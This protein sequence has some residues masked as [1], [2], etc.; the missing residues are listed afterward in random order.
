[1]NIITKV[2]HRFFP[3]IVIILI[4][5]G[6]SCL[7]SPKERTNQLDTSI[8]D[9]IFTLTYEFVYPDNNQSDPKVL[10]SWSQVDHELLAGYNVYRHDRDTMT[11]LDS[12]YRYDT[13]ITGSIIGSTLFTLPRIAPVESTFV[14]GS[15][16][17]ETHTYIDTTFVLNLMLHNDYTIEVFFTGGEHTYF[18]NHVVIE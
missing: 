6:N 1:M 9:T 15:T 13:T 8:D 2:L 18:S 17:I 5:I 4:F 7:L 11:V 14:L 3:L 16:D 10:L 12:W